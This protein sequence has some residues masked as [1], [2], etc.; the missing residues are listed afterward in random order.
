MDIAE[1]RQTVDILDRQ[2]V[3]LINQR[4]T[5]AHEI[6]RLKRE[7]GLPIYEPAREKEVLA[8]VKGA[9]QGPLTDRDMIS[10]YERIMD[11]MRKIQQEE[12][13]PESAE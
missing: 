12:I 13:A 1:W 9:N 7:A 2:V 10:I 6:G 5:A 3:D 11:M 4:A 8:N